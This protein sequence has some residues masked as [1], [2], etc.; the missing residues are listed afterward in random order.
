MCKGEKGGNCNRTA[1]Q[2]PISEDRQYYN[3]STHAWY[4]TRCALM[5]QRANPELVLFPDL[6]EYWGTDIHMVC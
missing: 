1:C 4:C 2:K 5:I 3:T 6:V